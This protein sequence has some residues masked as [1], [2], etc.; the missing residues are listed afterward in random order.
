V[1]ERLGG[2]VGLLLCVVAFVL[3]GRL[4][5]LEV[6]EGFYFGAQMVQSVC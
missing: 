5:V 1:R 6:S 3:P 2:V 4:F